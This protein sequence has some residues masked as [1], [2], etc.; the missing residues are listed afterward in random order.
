[1][2][3]DV[4]GQANDSDEVRVRRLVMYRHGLAFVEQ[5]GPA[6]G[7][8]A[9]SFRRADMDDVLKSLSVW[10][11]AGDGRVRSVAIEAPESPIDA[12]ASRN[13]LFE[14]GGTL[15]GM[16]A[17]LRGRTVEILSG[18][19]TTVGQ[20]L[21]TQIHAHHG[22]ELQ[23]GGLE[24]QL[25]LR[26]DSDRVHVCDLAKVEGLSLCETGSRTDLKFLVERLRAIGA[27]H[28][29]GVEIELEGKV[30]ELCVT[31]V[32]PAPVWK[33]SY[34]LVSTETE[35]RLLVW[36]I[37]HNPLDEDIQDVE[38]ILS[39]EQPASYEVDL[40]DAR[41]PRRTMQAPLAKAAEAESEPL[42]SVLPAAV[43]EPQPEA[44]MVDAIVAAAQA[45]AEPQRVA[46]F[47]YQVPGLVSIKRL[48]S[49]ML[50]LLESDI[51]LSRRRVWRASL[52]TNP[53]LR[54]SFR[55]NS[56]VAI[57]KGPVVLCEAKRF[58]GE[59]TMPEVAAGAEGALVFAHD[60]A[61]RC[62]QETNQKRESLGVKMSARLLIEEVNDRF[63]HK[64]R[65]ESDHSE[66]IELL[67]ELAKQSGRRLAAD[68]PVPCEETNDCWRFK[69]LVPANG[70][71]QLR[72]D[73]LARGRVTSE[74]R[75]LTGGQ[76]QRW[77]EAGTCDRPMYDGLSGVLKTW[78]R[79]AKLEQ[80][81]TRIGAERQQ[82]LEAQGRLTEQLATLRDS[83]HEGVLRAR[84]VADLGA[85]QDR[86]SQLD[87]E[88]RALG[89]EAQ[90]L[91][92]KGESQLTAVMER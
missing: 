28:S 51:S 49:C 56:G 11:S 21:G 76:L 16:L 74:L 43:D 70:A 15:D 84:L 42:D 75:H 81:C 45:A 8:F 53:E 19:T 57:A 50:P 92:K 91:R 54:F 34:R 32:V 25:I 83:G 80:E 58:V 55:N 78:A 4:Q 33:I 5:R 36:A 24:R 68:G 27:G 46:Q 41:R 17:S 77:L 20:V 7:S 37:V 88:L 9:L 29:R 52:G 79:A 67:F 13:L 73:E 38:L 59:T 69:V 35:A 10:V 72:V 23:G 86:L 31:Y 87:D 61:V 90:R 3:R 1:M 62:F 65:A 47:D 82:G 30:A 22:A 2:E 64:L 85:E 71:A 66:D 63:S 14:P 26:V 48:G 44:A 40:Y 39:T 12:L 6:E 60:R 89:A 18:E